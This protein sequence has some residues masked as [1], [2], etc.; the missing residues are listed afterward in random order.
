MIRLFVA[1]AVDDEAVADALM[2][3]Q[4]GLPGARWSPRENLHLTLRFVGEVAEP[5]ADDLDAALEGVAGHPFDLEF[6]G[7]GAFDEAGRPKAVW[8]GVRQNELLA[9]LHGR[10]HSAARRAG[11]PRD[12]RVWKP[13][14]T[15]AYLSGAEPVRVASW[16]AAH[17]LTRIPPLGVT[18]FGLY[19]SRRGSSG[20]S[21]T[22]ERLYP[23][24]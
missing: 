5:V 16:I 1:I 14:V 22:L 18:R 7:V 11:V 6:S 3:L 24:A 12:P 21:Y 13:H 10:C 9:V 4:V 20:P 8:A 2:A 19:S 15:L 23:L 17:N